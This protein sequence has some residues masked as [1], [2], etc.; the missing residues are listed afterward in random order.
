MTMIFLTLTILYI[1][2]SVVSTS[3]GTTYSTNGLF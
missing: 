2:Y 3:S 1:P